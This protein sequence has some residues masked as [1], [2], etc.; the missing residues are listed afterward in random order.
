[1]ESCDPLHCFGGKNY[2]ASP[3]WRRHTGDFPEDSDTAASGSGT[4]GMGPSIVINSGAR[5]KV[6]YAINGLGAGHFAQP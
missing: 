5:R 4:D 2:L 6:E 1:M 3:S